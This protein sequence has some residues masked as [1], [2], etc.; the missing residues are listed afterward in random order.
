[1]SLDFNLSKIKDWK[2]TCYFDHGTD[3]SRLKG[4]TE[5]LIWAALFIGIGEITETN[6][7]EFF[8]RVRI[9]E[10]VTGALRRKGDEPV[11]V[12]YQ[13][14]LDHIGLTTNVFPKES[15]TKFMQKLE[16]HVL[17]NTAKIRSAA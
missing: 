2:T 16:R 1:M 11:F 7:E 12:S 10:K 13:D 15:R 3:E 9:Y 8:I 5:T 4:V 6:A 14:V 17:E